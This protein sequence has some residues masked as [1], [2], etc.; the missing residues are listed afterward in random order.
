MSLV[1]VK[2]CGFLPVELGSVDRE[3][4]VESSEAL[5]SRQ[6]LG[7]I[8]SHEGRFLVCQHFFEE[9]DAS[10]CVLKF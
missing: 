3:F 2:F 6:M 1:C 4:S 8:S 9:L 5:K 10:L 7:F